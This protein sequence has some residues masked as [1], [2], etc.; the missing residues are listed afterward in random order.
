LKETRTNPPAPE[1]RPARC[2]GI[3]KGLDETAP[4]IFSLDLD[5][6]AIARSASPGQFVHVRA[7]D[8]WD[9]LW[10]RPFSVHRVGKNRRTIRLVFRRVGRGTGLLSRLAAGTGVDLLGPLGNGFDLEGGF[11]TAVVAAGGLGIAPAFFLADRLAAAK[12][13]IVLVWGA[14]TR[15]EFF[16][17]DTLPRRGLRIHLATEDGSEGYRGRVTGLLENLL[18][19]AGAGGSVR[20]FACGPTPM[21][22]S[23]APAALASGFAWQ[24]S[25]EERM[26]CGVGVCQGCVVRVREGG[27]RTVCADGPVFDLGGIEFDD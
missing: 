24:A 8:G 1:P 15:S 22:R 20:G 25:L 11:K 13:R 12:K 2:T 14:R 4:G 10:R 18:P 7:A 16:G 6:P 9:P 19:D 26:A 21:L 27:Y 5:A 3:V 17:L 23:L